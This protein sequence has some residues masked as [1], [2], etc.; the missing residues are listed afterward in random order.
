MRGR[1][2]GIFVGF[3]LFNYAL[4]AVGHSLFSY[5]SG[6]GRRFNEGEVTAWWCK[7]KNR[8]RWVMWA[9]SIEGQRMPVTWLDRAIRR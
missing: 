1:N 4:A 2:V 8:M 6:R 3:I 5:A 7:F 9:F